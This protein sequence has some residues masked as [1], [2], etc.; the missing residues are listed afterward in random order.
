ME[1]SWLKRTLPILSWLPA[2]DRSWLNVDV[3]AGP[4]RI[5]LENVKYIPLADPR[6]LDAM[7]AS[8]PD[9]V[10]IRSAGVAGSLD[11]TDG[12]FKLRG[13]SLQTDKTR[14]HISGGGE[15][16][17]D[18]DAGGAIL[19]G[20]RFVDQLS[21]AGIGKDDLHQGFRQSCRCRLLQ[22]GRRPG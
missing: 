6:A 9:E 21:H 2:Y 20:N 10:Q 13:L 14:A 7:M 22:S 1:N 18:L 12:T 17:L 5:P 3:I 4:G 11:L 19:V 16:I 8:V 15:I